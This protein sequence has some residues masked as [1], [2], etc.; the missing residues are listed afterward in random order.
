M[1]NIIFSFGPFTLY[2]YSFF[3]ACGFLAGYFIVYR[4]FKRQQM[5]L[6]FLNNYF[7]YLVPIVII[8]ARIWYVLFEWTKFQNN[9]GE[10]FAVWNGGLAVHG[11]ILAGIIWSLYYT[12]RYKINSLKF[13]DMAAPCLIIGQAIGRWG[14][15]FNQEAFGRAVEADALRR[16]FIPDF[17]IEGMNINGTYYHPT[18]LYESLACLLGFV[19]IMIVRR[20]QKTK[21]GEQTA[22]YFIVYGTARFFIE[23]LRTDS[24]MIGDMMI[25]QLVSVF[26]LIAGIVLYMRQKLYGKKFYNPLPKEIDESQWQAL[27][28]KKLAPEK[29]QRIE[30]YKKYVDKQQEEKEKKPEKK[31]SKSNVKRGKGKPAKKK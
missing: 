11:G 2:W 23:G 29:Q 20:R 8:G 19:I 26:M 7:F 16:M 30:Q 24:L 22:I 18:F 14:N 4:E 17:I 31:K 9:L 13:L 21:V 12:K 25:A 6:D 3:V 27:L 28:E 15:F 1:N 10:I 5:S